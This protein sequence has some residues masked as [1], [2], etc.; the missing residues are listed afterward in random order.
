MPY[1]AIGIN[2]DR[3]IYGTGESAVDAINDAINEA[4]VNSYSS[5]D[6]EDQEDRYETMVCTN[7]LHAQVLDGDLTY[8]KRHGH[9]YTVMEAAAVDEGLEV[10]DEGVAT[11]MIQLSDDDAERLG[12]SD[13]IDVTITSSTMRL[14]YVVQDGSDRS[15]VEEPADPEAQELAY[16]YNLQHSY[17]AIVALLETGVQRDAEAAAA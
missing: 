9:A 7:A 11:G 6:D 15:I 14:L 12:V 5:D 16:R 8:V 10:D 4:I 2:G 13:Q 3:T 17:D 1:I